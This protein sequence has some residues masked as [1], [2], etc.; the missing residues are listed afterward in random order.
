MSLKSK[1]GGSRDWPEVT[2]EKKGLLAL[3]LERSRANWP[4]TV[5]T[6]EGASA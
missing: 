4:G 2:I 3:V 1:G 6:H 5:S